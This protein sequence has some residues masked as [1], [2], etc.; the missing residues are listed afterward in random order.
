MEQE[1]CVLVTYHQGGDENNF[2]RFPSDC[3][4]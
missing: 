2:L 4:N 1:L 3:D